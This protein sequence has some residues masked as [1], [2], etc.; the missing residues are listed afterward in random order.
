LVKVPEQNLKGRAYSVIKAKII[1]CELRPGAL[2]SEKALIAEIGSSRTPIREALNKLEE[3]NWIRIYPKRGIFVTDI[4][5]KDVAD[6]YTLRKMNES[7]AASLAAEHID[8]DKVKPFHD[9]WGRPRQAP[10]VEE[11]MAKDREFHLLI[12]YASGNKYLAQFIS[13]LYDQASRVRFLSLEKHK[14]RLEEVRL[15]HL[16]IM[17]RLSAR[18][19]KGAGRAMRAHLEP[20][21]ETAMRLFHRSAVSLAQDS[22]LQL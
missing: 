4:S 7:L 5:A 2:L 13:R 6:I 15:E 17:E 11:H 8:L 22:L 9:L 19:K 12:A 21:A 10:E 3:E 1:R 14:D 16:A 20:A 18:D